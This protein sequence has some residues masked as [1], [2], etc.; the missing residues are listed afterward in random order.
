MNKINIIQRN[1]LS[2]SKERKI[3]NSEKKDK[4]IT[5]KR[6]SGKLN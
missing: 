6:S 1:K 3:T 2:L 5:R 4:K